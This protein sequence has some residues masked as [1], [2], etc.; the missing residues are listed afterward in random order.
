[1]EDKNNTP[2]ANKRSQ[3]LLLTLSNHQLELSCTSDKKQITYDRY[4][5]EMN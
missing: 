2:W 1:M 3:D 5:K 4:M